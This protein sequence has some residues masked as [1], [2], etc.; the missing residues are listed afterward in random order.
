MNYYSNGWVCLNDDCSWNDFFICDLN[1]D[2]IDEGNDHLNCCL[3]GYL[4]HDLN[5]Y[6]DLKC[7]CY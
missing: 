7:C 5:R 6:Y 2:L 1:E 3:N 4:D